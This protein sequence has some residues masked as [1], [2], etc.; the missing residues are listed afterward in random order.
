MRIALAEDMK[1]YK[2]LYLLM[3]HN[4]HRFSYSLVKSKEVAEEVVSDVFIKLWQLRNQ[5]STIQNLR[6]Y[7]YC[8]TKNLSL[9][10]LAKA[11]KNSL[12]QLEQIEVE[13][14]VEFRT[15][16]DIYISKEIIKDLKQAIQELP[17]QCKIVFLLVRD[18]ALTYK[19]VAK[20]LN[21]SVLT[22]RN[23]V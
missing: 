1:A 11:S 21:I 9:N 17:P 2:E 15:P 3:F 4:L 10:H 14:I 6:V 19:E 12:I 13:T 7:L 22:V 8:I 18:Q 23:Q 20:I 16:E 5:L